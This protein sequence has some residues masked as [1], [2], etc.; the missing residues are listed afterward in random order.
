MK[1]AITAKDNNLDAQVDPR[2]GRCAYFIIV[3]SETDEFTAIDNANAAAGS[4]AGI[5]AAQSIVK[6]DVQFLLTGNCGPN[7][8]KVC[9]AAGIKVITGVDGTVR[10]AIHKLKTHAFTVS[11]GPNV[12][13]H[14]GQG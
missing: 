8:F 1:I 4:G 9:D 10:E 5:Q 13:K 6:H 7:A 14:H 2:F 3:D 11:E 12:Q